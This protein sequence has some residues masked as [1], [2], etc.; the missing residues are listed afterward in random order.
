MWA[1]LDIVWESNDVKLLGITLDNQLKFDK[2]MSNICSKANRNLSD[3]T[4]VAKFLPFKKRR[5]FFKTFIELQFKYCPLVSM[6]HGKQIH[7][8]I[9]HERALRI[10]QNDTFTLFKELLVTNKSFTI[11][12]QNIG[13]RNI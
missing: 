6:F 8:K 4:R 3:L 5:I 1:K 2:H 13:N 9:N 7:N 12:H 10:V 11:H